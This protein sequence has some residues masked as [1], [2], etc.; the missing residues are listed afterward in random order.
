MINYY[1][2]FILKIYVGVQLSMRFFL[3]ALV[4]CL[5]CRKTFRKKIL[6]IKQMHISSC[7]YFI[8][9][10]QIIT[11]QHARHFEIQIKAQQKS[12]ELYKKNH[13]AHGQYILGS[14]SRSSYMLSPSLIKIQR[15]QNEREAHSITESLS[16]LSKNNFS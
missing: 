8:N 9:K 5:F 11:V 12:Q 16:R 4:L 7:K 1:T 2:L 15:E 3:S 14:L 10:D 6:N 13:S